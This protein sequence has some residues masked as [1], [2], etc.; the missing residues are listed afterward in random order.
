MYILLHWVF[1]HKEYYEDP[2]RE[3]EFIYADFDFPKSIVNFVRYM[4]TDQ[5]L[6]STVEANI[7]RL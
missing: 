6:L 1:E 7:E 2:L 3:V 4:P 5:P